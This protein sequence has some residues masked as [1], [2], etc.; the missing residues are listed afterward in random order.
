MRF[1]L[2]LSGGSQRAL[3]TFDVCWLDPAAIGD[4]NEFCLFPKLPIV[5][6]AEAAI[7]KMEFVWV[8]A[9][10]FLMG[11]TSSEAFKSERPLTR[12]RISRGYWLGKHRGDAGAVAGGNGGQ[13]VK[14]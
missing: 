1:S 7:A 14:I 10:E 6:A 8:P 5:K 9:G 13:S 12:V 11:S 4:V 3:C 2:R